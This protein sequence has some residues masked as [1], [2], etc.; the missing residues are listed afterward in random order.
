[1]PFDTHRHARL[2]AA[3]DGIPPVL[4]VLPASSQDALEADDALATE[5][6]GLRGFGRPVVPLW[7]GGAA[8]PALI[9]EASAL[10]VPAQRSIGRL[11]RSPLG[12]ARATRLAMAQRA[13]PRREAL[14]LGARVAA[15]ALQHGCSRIHAAASDAAATAALI[16]GRLGGLPVSIAGRGRDVYAEGEDLALKLAAADVVVAACREMAEDLQ[17]IAPGSR[18]HAVSGGIDADFF[19]REPGMARNGR[20][21]CV[22]PLLPR[23]G[24]GTL[25]AAMAALPQ[26]QR[27]E[28]DVVGT[29]PLLNALRAEAAAR[30]VEGQVRFLG[31]RGRRWIAAEGQRYLGLVA[32]GVVAPDGDRDPAPVAVLRAMALELP[33]V[34]SALMG[35]RE[36]VQPDCGHLVPPGEVMPLARGLRW[37]AVMPDE[38]RR[39][40]GRAGRDRVL[41]GYT[42]EQRMTGLAKAL[43][44]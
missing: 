20:L 12:L 35:L 6:A 21:L 18:V 43:A 37:L 40:F 7:L 19:R 4:Y 5:V 28:V 30:G 25:L 38:Q 29:G 14:Q 36:I 16:G 42:I 1:M 24:I 17:E 39:Q 27:P 9:A 32:P 31:G 33:V 3:T 8:D 22:A 26:G 2:P 11:A 23:S 13:L 15:A 41:A 44:G 34:A 10:P